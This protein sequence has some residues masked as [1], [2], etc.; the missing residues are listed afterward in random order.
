MRE[1]GRWYNVSIE[2]EGKI[3]EDKFTG[4]MDR[5][6]HASDVLRVLALSKVHFRIEGQT[7]V[8]MPD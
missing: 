8:V 4:T 7:I 3:P 6:M 2:Y 1:I 5:S